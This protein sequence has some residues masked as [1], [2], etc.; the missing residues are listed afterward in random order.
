VRAHLHLPDQLSHNRISALVLGGV[1]G[2]RGFLGADAAVE[3]AAVGDSQIAKGQ[4]VGENLAVG[5]VER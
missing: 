2:R 4:V 3:P 1:D 5:E